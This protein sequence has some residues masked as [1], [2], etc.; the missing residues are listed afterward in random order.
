ME[1]LNMAQ[2]DYMYLTSPGMQEKLLQKWEMDMGL[3]SQFTLT[4][5][6]GLAGLSSS[7]PHYLIQLTSR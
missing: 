1:V 3:S 5:C 4:T 2:L 6:L 7:H